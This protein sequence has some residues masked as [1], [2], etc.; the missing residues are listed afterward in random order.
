M[1]A[2]LQWEKGDFLQ[3]STR[4]RLQ[5]VDRYSRRRR[6][7]L[8]FAPFACNPDVSLLFA[9]PRLNSLRTDLAKPELVDIPALLKDNLGSSERFV[10]ECG[11]VLPLV[12]IDP[13]LLFYVHRNAISSEYFAPPLLALLLSAAPCI[14]PRLCHWTMRA[15]RFAWRARPVRSNAFVSFARAQSPLQR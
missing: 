10:L 3:A 5:C 14:G 2:G 7:C 6:T 11:E 8:V 13:H 4:A 9:H 15:T 1:Q 12:E